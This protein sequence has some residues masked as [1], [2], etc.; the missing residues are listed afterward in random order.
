MPP[1]KSLARHAGD[2]TTMQDPTEG[3]ADGGI[4]QRSCEA[5]KAGE[6]G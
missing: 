4:P 6:E 2:S 5:N 3:L 1:Q